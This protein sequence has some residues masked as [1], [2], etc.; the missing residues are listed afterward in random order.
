MIAVFY[1]DWRRWPDVFKGTEGL[2]MRCSDGYFAACG[3][4]RDGRASVNGRVC[5]CIT[6][7]LPGYAYFVL[8][9]QRA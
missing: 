7:C 4:I 1:W 8:K 9:Q 2:S 6:H 5:E 3:S